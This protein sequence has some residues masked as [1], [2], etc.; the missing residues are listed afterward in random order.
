M[1][2]NDMSALGE[3]MDVRARHALQRAGVTTLRDL[4]NLSPSDVLRVRGI[5][6]KGLRDAS[7]GLVDVALR[8]HAAC[9]R[10]PCS[11]CAGGPPQW[12][13]HCGFRLRDT[14]T[15]RATVAILLRP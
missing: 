13:P 5:G 2:P 4:G 6:P 8:T 1:Q 14:P 10:K 3:G 7:Q 9:G 11:R 15:T 12:C